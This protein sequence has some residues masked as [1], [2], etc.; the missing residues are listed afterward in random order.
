MKKLLILLM[1]TRLVA[2]TQEESF[3]KKDTSYW[4]KSALFGIQFSQS[5]FY[6]WTA[7]GEGYTQH[8][9]VRMEM[10]LLLP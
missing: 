5:S 7:G 6:Q 8:R 4:E 3:V 10:Q 9:A 2:F 1:L